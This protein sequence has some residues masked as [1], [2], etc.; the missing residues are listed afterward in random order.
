MT[1]ASP[2]PR[3]GVVLLV[4]MA[5]LALFA[6]V[7]LSFVFYAEAEADASRLGRQAEAREL[8]EVMP[9]KLLAY[10]LGQLIFDTDNP[11]SKMRGH[12]L[13]RSIYG[14]R[15]GTIP[16]SGLGR[17]HPDTEQTLAG[18]TP[19]DDG[20]VPYTYPDINNPFLACLD[21]NNPGFLKERSFFRNGSSLRPSSLP[22]P[23]NHE[24]D[25]R[26]I[27]SLDGTT[28]PTGAPIP[29]FNDA[30]WMDLDYPIATAKDGTRYKPLFALTVLDLDGRLNLGVSGNYQVD[31]ARAGVTSRCGLGTF[32]INP[33]KVLTIDKLEIANLFRDGATAPSRFGADNAPDNLL[34]FPVSRLRSRVDYTGRSADAVARAQDPY[35]HLPTFGGWRDIGWKSVPSNE[36]RWGPDKLVLEA[37]S[38]ARWKE[39]AAEP[40]PAGFD[41]FGSRSPTPGG[42]LKLAASN[43]EAILRWRDRGAH[44]LTSDLIR[45]LPNNLNPQTPGSARIFNGITPY[46]M[47]LDTAHLAPFLA[48]NPRDLQVRFQ[49]KDGDPYPTSTAVTQAIPQPFPAGAGEFG[50]DARSQIAA[51][52]PRINL[53][54]LGGHMETADSQAMAKEIFDRLVRL[55]GAIPPSHA[56]PFHIARPTDKHYKATR[57]LAQ[58]A[59]NIVDFLDVDDDMT[60]FPWNPSPQPSDAD[61]VFGVETNQLLIN[62][63]FVSAD[64]DRNDVK[65]NNGR[66]TVYRINAWAELLSPSPH[67][68]NMPF[69]GEVSLGYFKTSN[70]YRLLMSYD[71]PG[72]ESPT[73]LPKNLVYAWPNPTQGVTEWSS[74]VRPGDRSSGQ[75]VVPVLNGRGFLTLSACYIAGPPDFYL[76]SRKPIFTPAGDKIFTPGR[77]FENYKIASPGMQSGALPMPADYDALSDKLSKT[78]VTLSLQRLARVYQPPNEDAR[79]PLTYNPYVTVDF[80]PEIPV[81]N[82][83]QFVGA[84]E[85]KPPKLPA[86]ES[87]RTLGRYQ[88]MQA[89]GV[90]EQH[91]EPPKPKSEPQHTF[92]LQ[93]AKS[94]S[95]LVA[96]GALK[97]PFDTLY[98][99]DRA[100]ISSAE[101]L[102]APAVPPWQVTQ[103]FGTSQPLSAYSICQNAPNS[104]LFRFLE[105]VTTGDRSYNRQLAPFNSRGVVGAGPHSVFVPGKINLNTVAEEKVIEALF[106]RQSNSV[107]SDDDVHQFWLDLVEIRNTRAIA[108]FSDYTL[109]RAG[110][111][112]MR[113]TMIGNL[114]K[115]MYDRAAARGANEY[116]ATEGLRKVMNNITFT[117]NAF[118][119]W[120]TVGFFEVNDAG[121]PIQEIGKSEGRHARRRM[122]AIVDRSQLVL[123]MPPQSRPLTTLASDAA[124]GATAATLAATSGHLQSQDLKVVVDFDWQIKPGTVLTVDRGQAGEEAVVVQSA[125]GHQ[126]QIIGNGFVKPHRA[127]ARIDLGGIHGPQVPLNRT[128]DGATAP[129]FMLGYPGPQPRFNLRDYTYVVPYYSVI[130]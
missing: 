26:N 130:E 28:S 82:S 95:P 129:N 13:G 55:T 6:V 128:P 34:R 117:S 110:V 109:D 104:L 103:R 121:N 63:A 38:I 66:G 14:A 113:N 12:S 76:E 29:L 56:P 43:A 42:D 41:Y 123:P 118:A 35:S 8:A 98:H 1:R 67:E 10:A 84:T 21:P 48:S 57:W 87:L 70:I 99:F 92:Y 31:Y 39:F 94:V 11:N 62:E 83:V 68:E 125:N 114:F 36:I 65:N 119:V 116:E 69:F 40:H 93:N 60:P 127:G 90:K 20:N 75:K 23:P 49:W 2:Q 124:K 61:Y 78:K 102:L 32:E 24:G 126:L 50:I 101:A 44:A 22:S 53:N 89:T 54:R 81:H 71:A 111:V 79:D 19:I 80:F 37:P 115:K 5:M 107:F 96:G 120:L 108:G 105:T 18:L 85:I 100:L 52:L 47:S 72:S 122:F 15:G 16:Y 25:V 33:A 9:E 112:T 73:G 51:L 86:L 74:E 4:V 17:P 46:S 30:F 77:I 7:G 88:P 106:D 45:L 59:V 91:P 64:N 97:T 58:L 3:T 27:D